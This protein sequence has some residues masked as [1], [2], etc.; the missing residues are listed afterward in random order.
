MEAGVRL[1]AIALCLAL[2][3]SPVLA[4]KVS[5][6]GQVTYREKASLPADANLRIQLI[7]Q[8]LPSA[9][10][11]LDVQAPIGAG[12]VPLNFS[13]TFEDAIIIPDHSYALI[14]TISSGK[15]LM[16]RNF[17]PYAVDP[18]APVAPV[19]ITTSMVAAPAAKPH[20][21][22][23]AETPP[24]TEPDA[25]GPMWTAVQIGDVTIPSRFAPTL[26]IDANLRA[27]GTGGC[28]SWFAVAELQNDTMR[29]GTLA[30]TKK[31][32]GTD[33]DAVEASYFAALAAAASWKVETNT[34]TLYGADGS[35]LIVFNR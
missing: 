30:A 11:R 28:N 21:S 23:S 32:C 5:L 26:T 24:A 22:S 18:L 1:V 29:L 17:E 15:A 31:S 16:F 12:Q 10:P 25:I 14:A 2:A 20:D 19:L 7:D 4:A 33:R 6:P 27:G 3:A 9:P 35:A 34:L 8:S 13:L